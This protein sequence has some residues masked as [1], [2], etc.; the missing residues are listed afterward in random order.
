MRTSEKFDHGRQTRQARILSGLTTNLQ[1]AFRM[2]RIV[3]AVTLIAGVVALLAIV[4]TKKRQVRADQLGSVSN[5]WIAEH[6]V[7]SP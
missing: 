7:D 4:L 3:T 5:H 6:R 1:G 2:G